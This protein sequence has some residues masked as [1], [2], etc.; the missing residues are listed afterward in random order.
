MPA[1]AVARDVLLYLLLPMAAGMLV[2]RFFP[3]GS[4]S[5]SLWM[6]RASLVVLLIIAVGSL[7]SGR[8]DVWEYGWSVP[9]LLVAFMVVQFSVARIVTYLLGYD[10]ADAYTL[11][12]EVALR[13]GNLAILFSSTLFTSATVLSQRLSSG[14]LYVALFYGGA[15]LCLGVLMAIG[16][17]HLPPIER[18]SGEP[19]SPA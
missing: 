15:T 7:G 6:V 2:R 19:P 8:I 5:F 12:I 1:T 9:A 3:V 13:N 18:P 10:A 4:R 16:Q 17:R 14:V 11:A